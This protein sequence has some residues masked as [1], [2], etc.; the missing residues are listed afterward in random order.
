MLLAGDVVSLNVLGFRTVIVNSA[1]A[2]KELLEKRSAI[3]SSRPV[4]EIANM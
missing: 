1:S 4:M 3:Y 2:A